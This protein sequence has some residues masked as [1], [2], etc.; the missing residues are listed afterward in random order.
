MCDTP[1]DASTSSDWPTA[2]AAESDAITG[3]LTG[4]PSF[5][6]IGADDVT[7][8]TGPD[9]STPSPGAPLSGGPL[10]VGQAFGP[11]YRIDRLLG[12]GG[13]GAVYQAFD[14]E[15]GIP[16]ALKVILPG[17]VSDKSKAE[18]L[19]Q[20]FK[21][22]LLLA[23]EV[24]H[25]NVVR[26]H[27]I[28]ELKGIKYITMSYVHGSD[29]ATILSD[30]GTLPV[31]RVL[32]IARQVV[33]GLVA[34]HEAG[35]V[36]RDLKPANIMISAEDDEALIM[37]F[38][39]A[40]LTS[41]TTT[42][43]S[44][45][46]VEKR[47]KKKTHFSSV[48]FGQTSAG[49]VVGTAQYMAPEQAKGRR[50]DQ[51]ADVYAFGLIFREMFIKR[52][53]EEISNPLAELMK[54]AEAAPEPV[55]T[56]NPDF[57]QALDRMITRCLQPDRDQ[58]Y[59]S[60]AELAADLDKLDEDGE[61]LPVLRTLS[62]RMMAAAGVLVL[63]LVTGT[64]WFARTPPVPVEPELTS[65]LI[66]DFENLASDSVFDGAVEQAFAIAIEEAS[67]ITAYSRPGAQA[68]AEQIN[69]GAGLDEGTARLV[70]IREGIKL[71]LA[72]TIAREGSGYEISVR[73]L[74]PAQGPEEREP[75]VSATAFASTQAEVLEAVRSLASEIRGEL[76]DTTATGDALAEAE[77]FTA[78]SLQ[79]MQ[80]YARGQNLSLRGRPEE[81]LTALEEAISED[82]S[83][84]RAYASIA[85][86]YS[87]MQQS[88]QAEASF[89]QA[90]AHLDRM[91]ERERY[92]T[93]GAYYLI[94]ARNYDSA[95]ENYEELVRL[96]PADTAGHSNLALASLYVRDFDKAVDEG[97]RA[98]EI[99]PRN[100][101]HRANYAMY[102]M[103]AGDFET[104]V[105]EAN[106]VLDELSD[107]P[108]SGSGAVVAFA[109]FTIARSNV[110]TGDL[111]A[112][113]D[114]Y[115]RLKDASSL[116]ASLVGLG[117][118]DLAMYLG[119]Y[120]EA[121]EILEAGIQAE[122]DAGNRGNATWHLALAE[123]YQGLGEQEKAVEAARTSLE[124][125]SHESI[126]FPAA[127]CAA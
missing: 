2:A 33:A 14:Q 103:Y 39:V 24:T 22:E 87:N 80:A 121:A 94:V 95:I 56:V 5:E 89:Q 83:F 118:A 35:V 64:W 15:L 7:R 85:T 73:A 76:G 79:A 127:A 19:E 31:K 8:T 120:R 41:K 93:L 71:V 27:D 74:D 88:E 52:S 125:R 100:V 32:S 17:A 98:I 4:S 25:K 49:A 6:P 101:L 97:R 38:G 117:E 47:R 43:T 66:A 67:F 60:S 113:Q 45:G 20:R 48:T 26:I 92:R 58:R 90:L 124:L 37:D 122:Q 55:R 21:R 57:P 70:S 82:P 109:L 108:D 111:E 34:A 112:A 42:L 106:T 28:G 96:Y 23:R 62:R 68:L 40:R 104:A 69:P 99:Y 114:A 107:D 54:R 1:F 10:K 9:T 18:Q 46:V 123:A 105:T 53:S 110:A 36:H 65:V 44:S 115:A 102:A 59:Q 12:A 13:M 11:R 3:G 72:G 116:G 91:T 77:T 84:G 63:M 86:A 29:L 119:R 126:L 75:V 51:R 78:G 50:V 61:P 30:Q 81:A 16:V